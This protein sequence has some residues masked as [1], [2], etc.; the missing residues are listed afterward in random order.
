MHVCVCCICMLNSIT[1]QIDGAPVSFRQHRIDWCDHL[2]YVQT[3]EPTRALWARCACREHCAEPSACSSASA[4]SSI[5][6]ATFADCAD[7]VLRR[8]WSKFGWRAWPNKRIPITS[9]RDSQV[10]TRP[11]EREPF[12]YCSTLCIVPV[13]WNSNRVRND[14]MGARLTSRS[15]VCVVN[16]REPG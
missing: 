15:R 16:N 7:E 6:V 14:A 13:H 10:A 4:K 1:F 2:R 11:P 3:E 5:A 8:L 12:I 9:D